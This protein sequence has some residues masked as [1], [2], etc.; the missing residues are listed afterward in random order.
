MSPNTC[1]MS[2]AL[3]VSSAWT[4]PQKN[5][6]NALQ[7][8]I[9]WDGKKKKVVS[10]WPLCRCWG[11]SLVDH[12]QIW[13][14]SCVALRPV[15][16]QL[17]GQQVGRDLWFEHS[18]ENR[19]ITSTLKLVSEWLF[20]SSWRTQR[21]AKLRNSLTHHKSNWNNAWLV[22]AVIFVSMKGVTAAWDVLPL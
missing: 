9:P 17:Q 7:Q 14:S 8:H 16:P 5:V 21:H 6:V 11:S 3:N 10:D 1:M 20:V 2:P 12:N 19:Y 13:R 18:G 22:A 4:E 15:S